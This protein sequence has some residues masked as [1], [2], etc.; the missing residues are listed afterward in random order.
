MSEEKEKEKEFIDKVI[1][2]LTA[3]CLVIVGLCVSFMVAII[4]W[5]ASYGLYNA[6]LIA[7]V[8]WF[9]G[10]IVLWRAVVFTHKLLVKNDWL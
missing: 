9:L 8:L 5:S 10:A 1:G 4:V 2:Y 3:L 7:D 6:G